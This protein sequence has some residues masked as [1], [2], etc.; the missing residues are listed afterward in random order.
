[1]DLRH[2]VEQVS[3]MHEFIS[4]GWNCRE[5]VAPSPCFIILRR[6]S[7]TVT[8]FTMESKSSEYKLVN[9]DFEKLCDNIKGIYPWIPLIHPDIQTEYR[10]IIRGQLQR[11]SITKYDNDRDAWLC[12]YAEAGVHGMAI[13]LLV[14][15]QESPVR[16]IKVTSRPVIR[17][18]LVSS[19]HSW[20]HA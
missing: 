15:R 18:P 9:F 2:A 4:L 7:I 3:P 17:L 19:W 6:S 1:M 14:D 11:Y 12:F 13:F 10:N 20:W 16:P 5:S 8:K